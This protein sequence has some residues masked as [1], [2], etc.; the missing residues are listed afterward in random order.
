MKIFLTVTALSVSLLTG[1]VWY[2]T[3]NPFVTGF[4]FALGAIAAAGIYAYQQ[5][6]IDAKWFR[7]DA[8]VSLSDSFLRE[9]RAITART[10]S[11]ADKYEDPDQISSAVRELVYGKVMQYNAEIEELLVTLQKSYAKLEKSHK[12]ATSL[13]SAKVGFRDGLGT[14]PTEPTRIYV[15]APPKAAPPPPQTP[16][17]QTYPTAASPVYETWDP[18]TVYE[19]ISLKTGEKGSATGAELNNAVR[20]GKRPGIDF[21]VLGIIPR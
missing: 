5:G 10:K 7:R 2:Y 14:P 21:A 16:Y 20:V 13:T 9:L 17:T 11:F 3:Q 12:V 8:P 6:W 4:S 18:S 15:E 1:I 19:V